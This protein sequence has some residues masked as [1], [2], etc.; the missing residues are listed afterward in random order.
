[1]NID[2]QTLVEIED[3]VKY[4]EEKFG[5]KPE[6]MDDISKAISIQRSELKKLRIGSFCPMCD[7][8]NIQQRNGVSVCFDCGTHF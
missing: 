7:S 2:E 4:L 8:G 1:M 3:Y 5:L 6:T